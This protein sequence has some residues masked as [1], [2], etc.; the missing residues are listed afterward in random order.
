MHASR[1]ARGYL[2]LFLFIG[3][4]VEKRQHQP[5]IEFSVIFIYSPKSFK[6]DKTNKN[7]TKK[8]RK[9]LIFFFSLFTKTISILKRIY[10]AIIVPCDAS[11]SQIKIIFFKSV[12]LW[13]LNYLS[14]SPKNRSRFLSLCQKGH[15]RKEKKEIKREFFNPKRQ[16]G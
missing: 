6:F 15:E 8:E 2:F 7:P 16:N 12:C 4:R 3:A 14:V 1:L 9:K 10:V 5:V 13:L 11:S